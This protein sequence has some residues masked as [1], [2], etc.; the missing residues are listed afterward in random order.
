MI[1]Q[2]I[3]ESAIDRSS[4]EDILSEIPLELWLHA[5]LK[6][7]VADDALHLHWLEVQRQTRALVLAEAQEDLCARSQRASDEQARLLYL[8]RGT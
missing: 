6:R 5:R 3:P 1:L 4:E 2:A 8:W 7:D